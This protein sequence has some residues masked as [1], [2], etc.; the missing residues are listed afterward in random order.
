MPKL[1][2]KTGARP[3]SNV[4]KERKE[5]AIKLVQQ[6]QQSLNSIAKQFKIP[7]ST[8]RSWTTKK[9]PKQPKIETASSNN[10]NVNPTESQR[11]TSRIPR[12]IL[13]AVLR[14]HVT[15]VV[16]FVAQNMDARG[17]KLATSEM[18]EEAVNALRDRVYIQ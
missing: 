18:V 8:L 4:S 7:E 14:H 9:K 6:K 5:E 3:R 13:H 2:T 15:D 16:T 17:V 1:K 10:S 12:E 11:K